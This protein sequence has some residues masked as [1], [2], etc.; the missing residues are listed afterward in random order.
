[1]IDFAAFYV[2]D[3]M[4]IWSW[5]KREDSFNLIFTFADTFFADHKM[6]GHDAHF[7]QV[8]L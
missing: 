1:M 3:S 7:Y 4:L 8:L 5:S 6:N 2:K